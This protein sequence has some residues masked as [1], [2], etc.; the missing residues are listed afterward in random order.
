MCAKYYELRCMF[1]KITCD[2]LS[3]NTNHVQSTS[4]FV[5]V[6]TNGKHMSKVESKISQ[7]CAV[8]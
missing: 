3:F 7:G 5:F 6:I 1:Y 8:T 4:I 2:E